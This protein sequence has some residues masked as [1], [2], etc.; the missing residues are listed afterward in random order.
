MFFQDYLLSGGLKDNR[1]RMSKIDVFSF[2]HLRCLAFGWSNGGMGDF[3]HNLIQSPQ[4]ALINVPVIP[5]H[6]NTYKTPRMSKHSQTHKYFKNLTERFLRQ[7]DSFNFK[8]KGTQSSFPFKDGAWFPVEKSKTTRGWDRCGAARGGW[9]P[10]RHALCWIWNA[11][12]SGETIDQLGVE[13]CI[14]LSSREM[15]SPKWLLIEVIEICIYIYINYILTVII[16]SIYIYILKWCELY[17][18]NLDTY[19]M[20]PMCFVVLSTIDLVLL[21]FQSMLS[22]RHCMWI[23]YYS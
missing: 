3:S 23:S 2:S 4:I 7:I 16:W 10:L 22:K 1:Y 5:S 6:Y 9:L 12:L 15:F 14:P 13:G 8:K 20:V 19:M 18:Y 17:W 21:F 11:S